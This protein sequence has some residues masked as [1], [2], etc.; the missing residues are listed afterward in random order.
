VCFDHSLLFGVWAYDE[1]RDGSSYEKA[2]S[3]AKGRSFGIAFL[4]IA[5]ETKFFLQVP[6]HQVVQWKISESA[7]DKLQQK[8]RC[9]IRSFAIKP[10]EC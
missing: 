10:Q 9:Y 1:S 4:G 2:V 3:N 5:A 7:P 8:Q 6:G